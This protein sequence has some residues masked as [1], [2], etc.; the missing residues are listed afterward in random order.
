MIF[1]IINL[2]LI[3]LLLVIGFNS[4]A[5][6]DVTARAETGNGVHVITFVTGQGKINLYL[7]DKLIVDEVISGTIRVTPSGFSDEY[8]QRNNELLLENSIRFNNTDF[9]VSAERITVEVPSPTAGNV[10]NI[11]LKDRHGIQVAATVVPVKVLRSKVVILNKPGPEDFSL[12]KVGKA[13][14]LVTASGPFDG[15]ISNTKVR[16]AGQEIKVLA[17]SSNKIVFESPSNIIGA[18]E[19]QIIEGNVFLIREFTNLAV[20]KLNS[21]PNNMSGQ[22]DEGDTIEISIVD[23]EE[24]ISQEIESAIDLSQG[25]VEG[26]MGI[27]DSANEIIEE[28]IQA[29]LAKIENSVPNESKVVTVEIPPQEVEISDKDIIIALNEQLESSVICIN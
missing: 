5:Q 6:T 9:S 7:P 1:R 12:P 10:A 3:S 21:E 8:I 16:F 28:T 23:E 22:G 17:E 4:Y 13:G 11:I 27:S 18:T 20:V 29:E 14:R 19:V 24:I 26:D 25:A 15:Y 2:G